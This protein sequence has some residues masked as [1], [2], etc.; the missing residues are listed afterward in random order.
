[1]MFLPAVALLFASGIAAQTDRR[2]GSANRPG[3]APMLDTFIV[4]EKQA[5]EAWS[6]GDSKFFAGLL[7]NKFVTR[8][9]PQRLKKADVIKMVADEKCNIKSFSLDEPWMTK[10]N[11]DAY[12][13]GYRGTW[14]GTCAAPDGKLFDLPS[15]TRAATVWVRTGDKWQPGFHGVNAIVDP[16]E[17]SNRA[18]SRKAASKRVDPTTTRLTALETSVWEAWKAHDRKKLE[19]LTANDLSFIDIFGNSYDNKLD[20]MKAWS[21]G[22][23]KIRSVKVT[24]AV[25]FAL[26]PTVELLTHTGAADGTC[27]GQKVGAVYGNSIYVKVGDAWKLAFTMNMPAM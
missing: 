19:K 13:V 10:I 15:S 5:N 12:V 26:S 22:I 7:S 24:D 3:K 20:I 16:K 9:G 25:A 2:A 1:M 27:Y 21:S 4:L 18:Q 14:H 11:D 17:A 23:C 8:D 6:K